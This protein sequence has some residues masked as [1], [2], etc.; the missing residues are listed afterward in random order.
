MA[1]DKRTGDPPAPTRPL[2]YL[3]AQDRVIR[4][5]GRSWKRLIVLLV[6]LLIALP[7]L[8]LPPLGLPREAGQRLKCASQL[9][10]LGL[11]LQMYANDNA[12]QYR[13][14]MESVVLDDPGMS[15]VFFCPNVAE[16]DAPALIGGTPNQVAQQL[17]SA[18]ISYV[19][20]GKG[21]TFR[22]SWGDVLAYELPGHHPGPSKYKVTRPE[23]SVKGGHV[24]FGEGTVAF[25]P[26]PA[27]KTLIQELNAGQNPP[28]AAA[29][30]AGSGH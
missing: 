5:S 6:L 12:G 18:R 21:H 20:V 9:R 1:A 23:D 26:E 19:Y 3:S 25:V 15:Q 13:D 28:P 30:Y 8:L 11:A 27:L 10:Q 16:I 29:P 7:V 24:L 17:A 4:K 2:N 22:N 14:R